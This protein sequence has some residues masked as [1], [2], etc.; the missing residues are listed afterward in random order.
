MNRSEWEP[1]AFLG[2]RDITPVYARSQPDAG[3]HRRQ[4][5]MSRLLVIHADSG[6]EINAPLDSGKALINRIRIGKIVNQRESLRGVGT[7]IETDRRSLPIDVRRLI[8]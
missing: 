2:V 1:V 6:D 7:E 3:S 8:A 5:D 4:D